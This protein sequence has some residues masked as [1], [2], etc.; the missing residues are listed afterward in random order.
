MHRPVAHLEVRVHKPSFRLRAEN[1][2]Q[3]FKERQHA[4][5]DVYKHLRAREN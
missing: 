2:L 4:H 1:I 3:Y 5:P